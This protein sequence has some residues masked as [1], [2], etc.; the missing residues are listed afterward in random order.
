MIDPSLQSV[1]L[2]VADIDQ[3]YALCDYG[4][5]STTKA[6]SSTDTAA[7]N[8][9]SEDLIIEREPSPK[10][11][12]DGYSG[13]IDGILPQIFGP[14]NTGTMIDNFSFLSEIT[15]RMSRTSAARIMR[16]ACSAVQNILLFI[17]F[18]IYEGVWTASMENKLLL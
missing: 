17:E 12:L 6:L 16:G 8:I 9:E 3:L 7:T 2:E 14:T 18:Y 10:L 5:L 1:P 11:D 15:A 13:H 4:T